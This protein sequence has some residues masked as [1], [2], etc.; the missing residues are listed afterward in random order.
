MLK[1]PFGRAALVCWALGAVLLW[2]SFVSAQDRPLRVATMALASLAAVDLA[3]SVP[4]VRAG[5]TCR[6]VN[7]LYARLAPAPF[8][9][10]KAA[11]IGFA[12]M[13]AWTI[14]KEHPRKA[15]TL[16]IGMAAFQSA[17]VIHNARVR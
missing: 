6:E 11:G 3:Q 12:I 1:H 16:L 7:P 13:T 4:C 2:A 9:A 17:V 5:A 15:L 10:V 8:V 14:R